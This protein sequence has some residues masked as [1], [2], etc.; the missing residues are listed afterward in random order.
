VPTR[1]SYVAA[2][3]RDDAPSWNKMEPIRDPRQSHQLT[4]ARAESSDDDV[5][6]RKRKQDMYAVRTSYIIAPH[7]APAGVG[8]SINQYSTLPVIYL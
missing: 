7:P 1:S 5:M 2:Q 6:K 8:A 3:H 4:A